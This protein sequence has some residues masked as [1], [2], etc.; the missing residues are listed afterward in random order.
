LLLVAFDRRKGTIQEGSEYEEVGRINFLCWHC[1]AL[2]QFREKMGEQHVEVYKAL[3]VCDMIGTEM[4]NLQSTK[5]I[6]AAKM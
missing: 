4:G 3:L 6:F 1:L 5:Q 2:G